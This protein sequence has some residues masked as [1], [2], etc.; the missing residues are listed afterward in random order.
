M[1]PAV[2]I[3]IPVYKAERFFERCLQSLFEQTLQNIE[4]IFVND[5]TPDKSMEVLHNVLQRYPNRIPQVRIVEHETNRGSGASRDTGMRQATGEYVIHCDSDDWVELNMY[6]QM[7]RTA[8]QEKADIVCCDFLMEYPNWKKLFSY[9][10]SIETTQHIKE[11]KLMVLYSALWNKLV[12]R[13][14]ITGHNIYPFENVNMW[15]DLGIV[16]RLRYFSEKTVIIHQPFYHYNVQNPQSIVANK[17]NNSAYEQMNCAEH[18]AAFFRDQN[19]GKEYALVINYLFFL[20]KYAFIRQ[21]RQRNISL[22][23]TFHPETHRYIWRYKSISPINRINFKIADIGFPHIA[24]ILIQL[25]LKRISLLAH[26]QRLYKKKNCIIK[27]N[28]YVI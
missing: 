8:I 14:L 1:Q 9:D 12:R 28:K 3:I 17:N 22:W 20:S 5:H 19:A 18:I 11:L 26:I 2:S 10:Y 21:W 23:K 24:C 13:E 15:E 4:Y 27:A 16:T 25:N 6:E 7:Y